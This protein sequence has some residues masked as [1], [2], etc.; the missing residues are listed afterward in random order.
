MGVKEKL[1][2]PYPRPFLYVL[3]RCSIAARSGGIVGVWLV[4]KEKLPVTWVFV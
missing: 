3:S 2:V 4:R 1:G